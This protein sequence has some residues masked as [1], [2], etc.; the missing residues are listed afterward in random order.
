MKPRSVLCTWKD[1]SEKVSGSR[2][3]LMFECSRQEND[4]EI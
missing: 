1:T 4:F 2:L 3:T